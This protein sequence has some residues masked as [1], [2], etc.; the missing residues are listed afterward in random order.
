[1]I[2][3]LDFLV[4]PFQDSHNLPIDGCIR[5]EVPP[6]AHNPFRQVLAEL[7]QQHISPDQYLQQMSRL[8]KQ[9]IDITR[10]T[11]SRIFII[12]DIFFQDKKRPEIL[13]ELRQYAETQLEERFVSLYTGTE[14]AHYLAEKTDLDTYLDI[15][16]YGEISDRCCLGET[17]ELIRVLREIKPSLQLTAKLNIQLCPDQVEGK[18]PY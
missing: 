8:W 14:A 10:D 15:E 13:R 12:I 7:Q 5:M 1:M 6:F 3:A 9:R 17:N 2:T 18:F 4:K 16:A 11:R